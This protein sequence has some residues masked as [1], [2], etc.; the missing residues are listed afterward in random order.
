MIHRCVVDF[1]RLQAH[2]TCTLIR[3]MM[4]VWD[5]AM[6]FLTEGPGV[7]LFFF[8]VRF[9]LV[10]ILSPLWHFMGG[11]L[12]R[13]SDRVGDAHPGLRFY[14]GLRIFYFL[15]DLVAL[16]KSHEIQIELHSDL[17]DQDLF[18]PPTEHEIATS[19]LQE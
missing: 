7:C 12:V 4:E 2:V 6:P 11:K 3:V 10:V 14:L 19:C 17:L 1:E 5:V 18:S 15:L 9:H 8:R 16:T 13:D